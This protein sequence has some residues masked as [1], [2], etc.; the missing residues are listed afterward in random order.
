MLDFENSTETPANAVALERLGG[1]YGLLAEYALAS[2]LLLAATVVRDAGFT[3]WDTYAPF[4]VPGIAS[5]MGLRSTRLPWFVLGTGGCGFLATGVCLWFISVRG[6][7][8]SISGRVGVTYPAS[9]PVVFI[10]TVLCCSVATFVA[11]LYRN[12]LPRLSHPLLRNAAFQRVS[13]DRFFLAIEATDPKFCTDRTRAF[14]E[15]TAAMTVQVV[16]N[17]MTQA[18][19]PRPWVYGFSGLAVMMVVTLSWVVLSRVTTTRLPRHH[20]VTDMDVQ[21]K[22]LANSENQ[23]FADGRSSREPIAGNVADG[24]LNEDSQRYSGKVG[25]Q[26]ANGI[27]SA[28]PMNDALGRRGRETVQCLLRTLSR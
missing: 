16:E 9:V 7:P 14:L 27:P 18:T 11:M 24:E 22:T 25:E 28:I 20:W 3:Q 13:N 8:S 15:T 26:Y 21:R 6:Y 4:P 17:D 10:V 5:A 23:F 1:C 12:G 2:E 19:L